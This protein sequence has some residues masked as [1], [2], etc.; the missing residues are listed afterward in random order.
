MSTVNYFIWLA[1]QALSG[2]LY[3]WPVS[4]AVL[5]AFVI[6]LVLNNPFRK[7][8]VDVRLSLLWI[9]LALTISILLSGTLLQNELQGASKVSE[10]PM[11]L[12][13]G[14]YIAHIPLNGYL[15]Y[16]LRGF[17]LV[18]SATTALQVYISF[19]A[20]FVAGMAISGDWL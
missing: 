11:Y 3:I 2:M 10:W 17:R 9:P 16:S 8:H 13:L 1:D 14:L 6:A 7:K 15:I 19:W 18:A 12:I 5:I 4:L 20:L